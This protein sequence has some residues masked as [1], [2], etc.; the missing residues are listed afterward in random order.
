MVIP[1][2]LLYLDDDGYHLLVEIRAFDRVFKAVLDTGASRT[3]FDKQTVAAFVAEEAFQ[4]TDRL[5]TG[6]GTTSMESFTLAVPVLQ[7]GPLQISNFEAAVL[8]LSTINFTYEKLQ[9]EPVIGVIGGDILH[10]YRAVID[11]GNRCLIMS[12]E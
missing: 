1:L 3:V 6:L 11:Y 12:Y 10:K 5:S 2:T 8:D 7:I 4:D 9:L